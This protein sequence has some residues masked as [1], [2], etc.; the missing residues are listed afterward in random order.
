MVRATAR[1]RQRAVDDVI[2]RTVDNR[3]LPDLIGPVG[4]HEPTWDWLD[5]PETV[6][7]LICAACTEDWPCAEVKTVIA[8]LRALPT[9]PAAWLR[10]DVLEGKR[11]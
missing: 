11:W 9:S 8:E 7:I 3:S 10:A 2:E 5:E 1:R 4:Q 6:W